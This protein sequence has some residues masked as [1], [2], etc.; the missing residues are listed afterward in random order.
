[1]KEYCR[2]SKECHRRILFKDFDQEMT[3]SGQ[4]VSGCLC[5]DVCAIFL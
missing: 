4:K 2:N 3:E 5:C 1:M